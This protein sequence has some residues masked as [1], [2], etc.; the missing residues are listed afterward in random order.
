MFYLIKN[1]KDEESDES[2]KMQLS[3]S[4]VKTYI[5][6]IA[7]IVMI[8]LGAKLLVDN[9]VWCAI[10]FNIP[11]S[12][13]AAT[14][15]A[16]GTSVPELAVTITGALKGKHDIALGNIIGSCLFNIAGILGLSILLRPIN[17]SPDMIYFILP[18]MI[19]SGILLLLL[20]GKSSSI[21]RKKSF[22][23]LFMYILF[24]AYSTRHLF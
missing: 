3:M 12:I 11:R 4:V 7:G 8:S 10:K 20:P 18:L 24:I 6:L 22:L 5:L 23:L 15:I 2:D 17:V 13:I 1:S 16:F 14:V 9:V 21:N 19:I